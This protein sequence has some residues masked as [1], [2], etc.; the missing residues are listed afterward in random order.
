M[1]HEMIANLL[2]Q[3]FCWIASGNSIRVVKGHLEM[4]RAEDGAS[5]RI[6]DEAGR[7]ICGV[8]R[9]NDVSGRMAEN[10]ILNDRGANIRVL[11]VEHDSF[12]TED[13]WGRMS[14]LSSAQAIPEEMVEQ[15]APF[16]AS[17]AEVNAARESRAIIL[18]KGK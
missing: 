12:K 13:G 5:Y 2:L 11:F 3:I 16:L 9:T 10:A 18:P 7:W 17:K 1:N 6:I 4:A 8:C 14:W 15:V